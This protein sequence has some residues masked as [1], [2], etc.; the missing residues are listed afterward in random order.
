V[1]TQILEALN[2]TSWCE[3]IV[4]DGCGGGRIFFTDKD[5]LRVYDPISKEVILLQDSLDHP[6]DISKNG[7]LLFFV[8][9]EEQMR[10]DISKMRLI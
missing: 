5:S 10:F 8:C 4:G 9:K 3:G 2:A 6:K 1:Y 7:C